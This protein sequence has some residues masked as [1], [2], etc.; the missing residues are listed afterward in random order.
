MAWIEKRDANDKAYWTTDATGAATLE[1]K[2]AYAGA[3]CTWRIQINKNA[4]TTMSIV[5]KG[6]A[7]GAETA[8]FPYS[9]LPYQRLGD[10]T[11][12]DK[13]AG[14]AITESD[15]YMVRAD[16]LDVELVM[17]ANDAAASPLVSIEPM[18]G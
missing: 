9:S 8:L 3:I 6:K 10:A 4:S 5:I 12:I 16:G 2:N 18:L 14:V 15:I 7:R 17:S 1:F 13:L 11:A